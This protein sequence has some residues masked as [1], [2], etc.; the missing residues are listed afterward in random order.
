MS[1][2]DIVNKY[3]IYLL[4]NQK[5]LCDIA[6]H[7]LGMGHITV[8]TY[9]IKLEKFFFR[10]DGGS[11]GYEREINWDFIKNYNNINNKTYNI[12]EVFDIIDNTNKFINFVN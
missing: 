12:L 9:D 3:N 6:I 11:N 1:F 8:L 2:N 10:R 5:K 7:Y 4:N